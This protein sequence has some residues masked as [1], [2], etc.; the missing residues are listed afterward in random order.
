MPDMTYAVHTAAC[1][2]LLDDDG[3][4]RAITITPPPPGSE[5]C[6]G[7]QFVACLDMRTEGGLVG[8]L[9]AGAAALFAASHEGRFVLLRTQPIARVEILGE[10]SAPADPG[11]G[12]TPVYRTESLPSYDVEETEILD[13]AFAITGDDAEP[14]DLED[15][16][17]IS[18]TEVTVSLP[19]PR[20]R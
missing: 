8:E 13:A 15:F 9:R 18:V 20:P 16:L 11:F 1:T 17:S 12:A 4:C 3:V 5:R 19:R 7:A 2:Y 6:I 14:L 10:A